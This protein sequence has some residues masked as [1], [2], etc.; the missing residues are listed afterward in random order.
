MLKSIVKYEYDEYDG[1][2]GRQSQNMRIYDTHA[3]SKAFMKIIREN[4]VDSIELRMHYQDFPD[5]MMTTFSFKGMNLSK[6]IDILDDCI[7]ARDNATI[8][9]D[10]KT[11]KCIIMRGIAGINE[12][13]AK[14]DSTP[15]A[16]LID[17]TLTVSEMPGVIR[18]DT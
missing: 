15:I 18:G 3:L 10:S 5:Y 1:V 4:G 11:D 9:R 8:V 2:P 16:K 6:E 14:I 17:A 12:G 7:S 13:I